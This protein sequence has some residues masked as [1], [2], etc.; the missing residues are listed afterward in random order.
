ML[1]CRKAT[2]GDVMLYFDWANDEEV[3]KNSFNQNKIEFEQ[4]KKWFEN[5]LN[6]SNCLMFVASINQKKVGQ[7]RFD[8][9]NNNSFEIDFS[10]ERN[11]RGKGIGS[12]LI[13]TG[14]VELF[15]TKPL[16]KRVIGKVKEGNFSSKKSFLNAG[17]KLTEN[18]DSNSE[19]DIYYFDNK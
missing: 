2:A 4:H 9:I 5:K 1:I 6:D 14:I 3:R 8:K 16:V 11:F 7:I 17:F 10:I 19:I 15:K 13:K 18:V 12:T